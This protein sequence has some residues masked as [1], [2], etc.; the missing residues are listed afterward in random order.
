MSHSSQS[1]KNYLESSRN[2]FIERLFSQFLNIFF[3]SIDSWLERHALHFFFLFQLL[4]GCYFLF[5]YSLLILRIFVK[6]LSLI[7]RIDKFKLKN[8]T[9]HSLWWLL[10]RSL[11]ELKVSGFRFSLRTGGGLLCFIRN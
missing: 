11:I 2:T 9:S 7:I 6:K 4:V 3:S 1:W 8:R 5:I 10:F